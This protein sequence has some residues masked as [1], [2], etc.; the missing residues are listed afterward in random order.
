MLLSFILF[1][2][3]E[4]VQFVAA[5]TFLHDVGDFNANRKRRKKKSALLRLR[6]MTMSRCTAGGVDFTF[7]AGAQVAEI[8]KNFLIGQVLAEYKTSGLTR[9]R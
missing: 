6:K 8:A 2:F 1:V 4:S 7:E 9:G 5:S 3:L